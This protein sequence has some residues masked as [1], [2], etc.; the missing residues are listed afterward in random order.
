VALFDRGQQL[1]GV[2]TAYPSVISERPHSGALI[3]GVN[4]DVEP[5]LDLIPG[6]RVDLVSITIESD[7]PF[8]VEDRGV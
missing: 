5:Q 3:A 7:A 4:R 2:A 8:T 6:K 1:G